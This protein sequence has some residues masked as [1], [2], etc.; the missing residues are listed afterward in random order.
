MFHLGKRSKNRLNGVHPDLVRVV[1]RAIEIT[2][3]DFTVLEGLRSLDRQA[4]LLRLG[5]SKTMKSRH[6][7]G[8]A[9][10][11]AAMVN[12]VISWQPD[13]YMPI[14]RAMKHAAAELGI[15]LEWGGDWRT[16]KDF[17][18]WQ[19]SWQVYPAKD[20]TH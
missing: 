19:L 3:T 6:L 10:D 11:L 18:H 12:G 2:E 5:Q 16:F 1:K 14:A 4:A 15:K 17:V 7:T 20:E 9:V 8:H 13:H